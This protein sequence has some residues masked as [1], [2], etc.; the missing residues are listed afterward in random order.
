MAFR[1]KSYR[2]IE[3]ENADIPHSSV[4]SGEEQI[5]RL[6]NENPDIY[7]HSF[8]QMRR[9]A[10]KLERM[11]YSQLTKLISRTS[12]QAT[13]KLIKHEIERREAWEQSKKK[14]RAARAAEDAKH[15]IPAGTELIF[16]DEGDDAKI[17]DIRA[18]ILDKRAEDGLEEAEIID[19]PD[20]PPALPLQ[21]QPKKRVFNT[22]FGMDIPK[23]GD[24]NEPQIVTLR[25]STV[26]PKRDTRPTEAI[27]LDEWGNKGDNGDDER[28]RRFLTFATNLIQLEDELK[29]IPEDTTDQDLI[30]KRI[31]IKISINWLNKAL[32]QDPSLATWAIKTVTEKRV[33][34]LRKKIA[35][36]RAKDLSHPFFAT[37]DDQTITDLNLLSKPETVTEKKGP[38]KLFAR[39]AKGVAAVALVIGALFGKEAVKNEPPEEPDKSSD[40]TSHTGGTSND[41]AQTFQNFMD[42]GQTDVALTDDVPQADTSDEGEIGGGDD[43]NEHNDTTPTIVNTGD[44]KT[45]TKAIKEK[46]E[47][48]FYFGITNEKDRDLIDA[49]YYMLETDYDLTPEQAKMLFTLTKVKPGSS[50][51]GIGEIFYGQLEK[52]ITANGN[53]EAQKKLFDLFKKHGVVTGEKKAERAASLLLPKDQGIFLGNPKIVGNYFAIP[54]ISNQTNFTFIPNN[55]KHGQDNLTTILP[56]VSQTNEAEKI[57]DDQQPT[58]SDAKL[59]KKDTSSTSKADKLG[60][61]HKVIDLAKDRAKAAKIFAERHPDIKPEKFTVNNVEYTTGEQVNYTKTSG[62]IEKCF[63]FAASEDDGLVLER[64]ND[65]KQFAI[66]KKGLE[67][68]EK[69]TI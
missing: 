16:S 18:K 31:D 26:F 67:R 27:P 14:E 7:E 3:K 28:K 68:V 53:P 35:S 46:K 56:N 25:S 64:Q 43:D 19:E 8:L 66:G 17:R 37:N 48:S 29:T 9:K 41:D 63:V 32:S 50:A 61:L 57:M 33:E 5:R 2:L 36:D 40:L 20:Q 10:A 58:S 49:L 23:K 45:E 1:E 24:K 60:N 22:T 4:L 6:K 42:A 44:I 30:K 51:A 62:E 21:L 59:L 52:L 47:N 15:P 55:E 34:A 13:R 69:I 12:D 54:P 11:S 38:K 39:I 65:R